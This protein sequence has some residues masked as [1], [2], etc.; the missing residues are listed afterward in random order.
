MLELWI[1]LLGVA[2]AVG[3]LLV[4]TNPLGKVLYLDKL[5]GM[6]MREFFLTVNDWIEDS[7]DNQMI[8]T[9]VR[10]GC[11]AV[12]LM[13]L[14]LVYDFIF[15]PLVAVLALVFSLG[16]P[17]LAYVALAISAFGF[18]RGVATFLKHLFKKKDE[19]NSKEPDPKISIENGKV[20]GVPE[21]VLTTRFNFG[22]P[23]VRWG[24]RMFWALPTLYMWYVFYILVSA[25]R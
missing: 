14:H 11:S 5:E 16:N 20:T 10:I 21:E 1:F 8:W 25:I 13:L 23:L 24:K 3:T 6:T 19:G 4:F 15:E 7:D 17:N 22:N 2:A 9:F 18:L 12:A